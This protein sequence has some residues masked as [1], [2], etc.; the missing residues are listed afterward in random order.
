M[1][2]KVRKIAMSWKIAFASLIIA[3]IVSG[4]VSLI[5]INM[6]KK[7]L[8][9][10]SKNKAATVARNAAS[11]VDVDKFTSLNEGDEDT[12]AFS[13]IVTYLSA[14][15]DDDIMY[16]YTMK[17]EAGVVSFVVDADTEDG[18]AIGEEYESYEEIDKAKQLLG[19]EL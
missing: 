17:E 18:A 9:D 6:I 5:S 8:L 19:F 11:F 14:F 13:E 15:L 10:Q 2:R 1:G 12:D 7:S 16:I 3:V 4:M